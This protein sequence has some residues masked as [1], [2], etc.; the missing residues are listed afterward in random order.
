MHVRKYDDK[1]YLEINHKT[2]VSM[3]SINLMQIQMVTLKQ[4]KFNKDEPYI[5]DLTFYRYEFEK[6]GEHIKGYTISKI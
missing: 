5:M 6:A 3:L 1:C 4:I 2:Y